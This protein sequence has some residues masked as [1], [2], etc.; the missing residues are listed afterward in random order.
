MTRSRYRGARKRP[1]NSILNW[2]PPEPL[3]PMRG[4]LTAEARAA[5]AEA[6][7]PT[8]QARERSAE[9]AL[10]ANRALTNFR[11]RLTAKQLSAGV[12]D[13]FDPYA[14]ALHDKLFSWRHGKFWR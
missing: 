8:R 1:K 9:Q 11:S 2:K 13:D 3:P 14:I 5:E 12:A 4:G 10:Q 7:D 6:A